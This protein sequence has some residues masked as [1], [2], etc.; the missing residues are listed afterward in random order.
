MMYVIARNK[1]GRPTLMHVAN[2]RKALCGTRMDGW[3]K[4]YQTHC[5]EVLLCRRCRAAVSDARTTG[6]VPRSNSTG[7]SLLQFR[8]S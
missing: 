2:G 8:S 6:S 4:S 3:S 7:G 1:T 5:L